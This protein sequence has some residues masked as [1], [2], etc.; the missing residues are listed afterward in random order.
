MKK[1][2]E[3]KHPE[4]LNYGCDICGFRDDF[5][6]NI[7]M[8]KIIKHEKSF[9]YN[10]SS[11]STANE[12][13]LNLLAEQNS[14]LMD[15]VVTL[16]NFI[17][18]AF[19]NF[20]NEFVNIVK[21]IQDDEQKKNKHIKEE[22]SNLQKKLAVSD[23]EV[24]SPTPPILPDL[25]SP[26]KPI[27]NPGIRPQ[28][29]QT[30]TEYQKRK[31][32]LIVGDSLV[33][34][35]DFRRLE[36][37]TNST[38]KTAHA[39]SSARDNTDRFKDRNITDVTVD[40]LKKAAFNHLVIGA[41][42]VD[43]TNL[44]T[45]SSSIS[46]DFKDKIAMSC[47]NVMKVA[48]DALANHSGLEKVTIMSHAPRYDTSE[49]DPAGL[50]PNLAAFANSFLLELW[51]ESPLKDKI[52]IG[53][54]TNLECSGNLR[55][56]RFTAEFTGKYDGVHMYG[57]YGK[58]AYTESVLNILLSSLSL[59]GRTPERDSHINCP[60]AQYTRLMKRNTGGQQYLAPVSNRRQPNNTQTQYR[61]Y[62]SVVASDIKT[63]NRFSILGN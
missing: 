53:S 49:A 41:P 46:N 28:K 14:N 23:K 21:V 54:H 17:K 31:R 45:E 30:E 47:M 43:I 59:S 42:T 4:D 38:I 60:Q 7:W 37:A 50:K 10:K 22:L 32:V 39:Y 19:E 55:T 40:E 63:H 48:E 62:S 36:R 57:I 26:P 2:L 34:S 51:I 18:E 12:L 20:T 5:V 15:E 13:M 56:Q 33:H 24:L 1:H 29:K 35:A 8:H 9:Q 3:S 25:P 58:V 52:F 61:T 44:C 6:G 16:K 27:E 11:E